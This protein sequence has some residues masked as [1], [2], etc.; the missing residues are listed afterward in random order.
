MVEFIISLIRQKKEVLKP[1]TPLQTMASRIAG[2]KKK[3]DDKTHA[4]M[5]YPLSD[6]HISLWQSRHP[7]GMITHFLTCSS[8]FG[9]SAGFSLCHAPS[10]G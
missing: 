9:C 1:Q 10:N 6:C 5:R 2:Q 3:E 4:K 7:S 8:F